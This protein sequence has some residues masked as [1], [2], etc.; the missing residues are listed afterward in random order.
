[1]E[2]NVNTKNEKQQNGAT[3]EHLF[4]VEA[5]TAAHKFQAFSWLGDGARNADTE[6]L[7][8]AKDIA[9][10]VTL[11]LQMIEQSRLERVGGEPVLNECQCG[12]FE[13]L[14]IS[15]CAM[16]DTMIERHLNAVNEAADRRAAA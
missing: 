2:T 13:R 12:I 14:S 8:M 5:P 3:V 10:G 7:A 16:L 11:A 9:S 4:A 6:M 15:S 1:M